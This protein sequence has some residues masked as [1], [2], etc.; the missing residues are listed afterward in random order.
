MAQNRYELAYDEALRSISD[1]QAAIDTLQMR[2]GIVASAA[3]I[4]VSVVAT[5]L[6][7]Q[8]NLPTGLRMALLGYLGIAGCTGFVLW[9]RRKWRLHFSV[10]D[11]HWSFIEGPAPASL[12]TMQR[13][14]SL[15]LDRYFEANASKVDR[16]A[17]AL[18]MSIGLLFTSTAILVFELWSS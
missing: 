6:S 11:L 14:L 5:Q 7:Q 2:A 15:Y 1:Q 10:S 13:D 16:M 9:P 3:A 18:T 4:V 8:G 12:E 17:W